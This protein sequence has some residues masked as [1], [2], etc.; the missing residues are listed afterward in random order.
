MGSWKKEA[1]GIIAIWSAA[2]VVVSLPAWRSWAMD[3]DSRLYVTTADSANAQGKA[4]LF[5]EHAERPRLV[6]LVNGQIY[7]IFLYRG[8]DGKAAPGWHA[9][10]SRDGGETWATPRAI[11]VRD[12]SGGRA[13]IREADIVPAPGG[14]LRL[15]WVASGSA[16]S[17]PTG[18]VGAPAAEKST[19]IRSAISTDGFRFEAEPG[20]RVS[21]DL[22]PEK[23]RLIT[24]N[25]GPRVALFVPNPAAIRREM[26][27]LTPHLSFASEN[28]LKFI[29]A[30][31]EVKV[32]AEGGWDAATRG[33]KLV[34]VAARPDGLVRYERS[35]G[36]PFKMTSR[37]NWRG[38]V[39]PAVALGADGRIVILFEQKIALSSQSAAPEAADPT[40][41]PGD[42]ITMVDA[43]TARSPEEARSSDQAGRAAATAEAGGGDDEVIRES[44]NAPDVPRVNLEV[45]S[46]GVTFS[47]TGW[48]SL[49][50]NADGPGPSTAE[51]KEDPLVLLESV[52]AAPL[53]PD[54]RDPMFAPLPDFKTKV[55]YL[56]WYRTQALD[57][58]PDNAYPYYMAFMPGSNEEE[59]AGKPPWPELVNMF[60]DETYDGPPIPWDET[61]HPAWAASS[62]QARPLLDQFRAASRHA[63]YSHDAVMSADAPGGESKLLVGLLLPALSSHRALVKAAVAD[64]WRMTDG[65]VSPDR[66]LDSWEM[67]LRSSAHLNRGATLIEHLV[68]IAQQSLIEQNARQALRY[69]IFDDEAKLERALGVLEAHD[70]PKGDPAQ[71]VRGEHA[72]QMDIIQYMFSKNVPDGR[73][74]FNAQR[75]AEAW[76]MIGSGDG[77]PL[78]GLEG[79]TEASVRAEIASTDRFFHDLV[80][81][82]REG[83][84]EVKPADLDAMTEAATEAQPIAK[85]LMPSLSRAYELQVRQE[86]TRRGTQLAFAVELFHKREGRYPAALEELPEKY[87]DTVMIDPFTDKPFGYRLESTGPRLYSL[88]ANGLDDGGIHSRRWKDSAA[89]T[90]GSD[91]FVFYPPQ[92]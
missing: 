57:Q 29:P 20:V 52:H 9:S 82:I 44:L 69:G 92:P 51:E 22:A 71:W 80:R 88:S 41:A 78:T 6:T 55:D 48:E 16:P 46:A 13:D 7:A 27:D 53:A 37:L 91:D 39:D 12:D 64:G 65:K 1:I 90:G 83:Y 87:H 89:E 40:I 38:A 58:T 23:V 11:E 42:G 75:A 25:D 8:F 33:E 19:S 60:T 5:L 30:E 67:S 34:A 85:V 66:M 26:R 24:A 62:D 18:A 21:L 4:K 14:R 45:D 15:Y 79:M 28:G 54:Q 3:D 32:Q 2:T 10:F 77:A 86:A 36:E 63:G 70:G 72:F 35:K 61:T 56:E 76:G 49:T 74:E 47:K 81:K 31:E 50:L 68:A 73:V 17:A 43:T 59:N 84:P